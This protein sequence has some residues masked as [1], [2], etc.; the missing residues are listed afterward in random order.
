MKLG[1]KRGQKAMTP[2]T[3]EGG[4]AKRPKKPCARLG[5]NLLEKRWGGLPTQGGDKEEKTRRNWGADKLAKF[6][7]LGEGLGATVLLR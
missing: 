5:K 3:K 2:S 1:A 6:V 4:Q 7:N